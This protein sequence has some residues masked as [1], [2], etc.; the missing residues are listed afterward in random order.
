M[1][2]NLVLILVAVA[3][4]VLGFWYWNSAK[5]QGVPADDTTASI[6]KELGGVDLGDL[7]SELKD[8]EADLSTL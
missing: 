5:E 7:D 2:K 6:N 3:L 8:I 4:I 1:K